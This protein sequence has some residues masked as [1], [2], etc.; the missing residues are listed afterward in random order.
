MSHNSPSQTVTQLRL[1]AELPLK[2]VVR[3]KKP[4]EG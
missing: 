4:P 3:E 1:E 2:Q